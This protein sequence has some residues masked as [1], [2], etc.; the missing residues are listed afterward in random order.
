MTD[1]T[2]KT[3]QPAD[4]RQ[5]P[6]ALD[7]EELEILTAYEDGKTTS[8]ANTAVLLEQHRRYAEGAAKR[9]SKQMEQARVD[10]GPLN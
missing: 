5:P 10:C 2:E 8:V 1:A 6:D 7:S 4:P 3:D 9:Q